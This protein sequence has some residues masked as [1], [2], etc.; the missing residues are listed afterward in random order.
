MTFYLRSLPL[1]F[2]FSTLS[3]GYGK[4]SGLSHISVFQS[5]S[6]GD[7]LVK[8][9]DLRWMKDTSKSHDV[10][11]I[12]LDPSQE[13]QQYDGVGGSFMRAGAIVLN[14][15]P[16]KVSTVYRHAHHMVQ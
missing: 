8:K 15:L 6:M 14:K 3:Y 11:T 1:L 5:D 4:P 2:L 16:S 9:R 10:N 7:R 12:V 13:Y